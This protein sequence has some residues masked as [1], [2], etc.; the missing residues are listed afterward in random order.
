LR[1]FESN[2]KAPE[3]AK[4][5]ALPDH[6]FVYY[7]SVSDLENLLTKLKSS[8]SLPILACVNSEW[9]R[10]ISVR[11]ERPASSP[12]KLSDEDHFV[13]VDDFRPAQ[14]QDTARVRFHDA[15][16]KDMCV[17]LPVQGFYDGSR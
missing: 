1:A 3:Y 12:T 7:T 17:W 10:K 4:N 8:G 5:E 15:G 9:L 16:K 13:C 11:Y 2:D 14:Q 6:G